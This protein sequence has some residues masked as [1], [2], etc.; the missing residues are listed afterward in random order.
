MFEEVKMKR[1]NEKQPTISIII[2]IYNA[3]NL[4]YKMIDCL[5][6]QTFQEFEVILVNDGSTD[7]SL[8][9]CETI[10]K[11]H[12]N[13]FLFSQ[14]NQG[15]FSARNLGIGKARGQ[16]ITFLDADDKVDPNYLE[17]LLKNCR[18]ADIAICDIAVYRK[19]IET[20]RFTSGN[21]RITQHQALNKLL[22][23]QEINSGPYGKIFQ[24]K[25]I[26]DVRFPSLRVY[27]DILFVLESFCRSKKIVV[28]NETTYYYM[29]EDTGTMGNVQKTPSLDIVVA[30]EKI[31]EFIDS[32]KDLEDKCLYIT[33][34][35]LFQYALPLT[36]NNQYTK[37]DFIFETQK[38][39]K[40]Y[41]K[42]ILKCTAIPW[43]EKII[44][45]LYTHSW[46]YANGQMKKI[47]RRN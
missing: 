5:D 10:V 29:Q 9:I 19:N 32:R 43:K 20:F 7:D 30:T 41:M 4:I 15:A 40:K 21:L 34:S 25:V 24:K 44:F 46:V 8:N 13:Y 18:D 1:E 36:I 26:E 38:L 35:H 3:G 2:P 22:I 27:E 14:R 33:I 17:I 6:R 16:Y 23:R 47:K 39:Y 11:N 42:Q 37:C 12:F 28:T 31:M 45:Y